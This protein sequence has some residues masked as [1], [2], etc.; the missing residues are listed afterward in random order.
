MIDF[1]LACEPSCLS[2]QSVI[3]LSLK[4]MLNHADFSV[5]LLK[6]ERSL[7]EKS[8]GITSFSLSV[9]YSR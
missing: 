1:M 3:F 9:G 7:R 8:Y 6:S 5:F 2:T 4:T